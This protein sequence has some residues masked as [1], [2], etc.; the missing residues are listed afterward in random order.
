[1]SLRQSYG[2]CS[3]LGCLSP[4]FPFQ[5]AGSLGYKAC[6]GW[7]VSIDTGT[8]NCVFIFHDS[9]HY[10]KLSTLEHGQEREESL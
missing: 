9:H 5:E 6:L 4:A 7:G 1:M 3:G 2:R 10:L 8:H